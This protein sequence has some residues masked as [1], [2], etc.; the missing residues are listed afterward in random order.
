LQSLEYMSARPA[1]AV[2][3]SRLTVRNYPFATQSA[4]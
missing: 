4:S 1:L 2:A 3:A